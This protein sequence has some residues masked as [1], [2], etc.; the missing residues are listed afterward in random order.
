M[1][2][3]DTKI[4]KHLNV[5]LYNFLWTIGAFLFIAGGAWVATQYDI[6]INRVYGQ[7]TR[8]IVVA[9]VDDTKGDPLTE[10]QLQNK[11][12]NIEDDVNDL[13]TKTSKHEGSIIVLD[14]DMAVQKV[15]YNNIIEKLDEL[16]NK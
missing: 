16:I 9:H 11:V 10:L 7:E 5:G 14:R 1:N 15:Q 4:A 3:K 2:V 6:K 12:D 8:K 13:N